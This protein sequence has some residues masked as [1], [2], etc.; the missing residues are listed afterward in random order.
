[1]HALFHEDKLAVEYSEAKQVWF[2]CGQLIVNGAQ[3]VGFCASLKSMHLPVPC[4]APTK[5]SSGSW[6]CAKKRVTVDSQTPFCCYYSIF[7]NDKCGSCQSAESG[8]DSRA[9]CNQSQQNCEGNC[10]GHFCSNSVP[11]D[12]ARIDEI[13]QNR[14]CYKGGVCSDTH[15][16]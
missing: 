7:D 5:N 15:F 3:R 16:C 9:W 6:K 8:G 14:C 1:M 13:G 12:Q 4:K 2:A 11:V 10:G